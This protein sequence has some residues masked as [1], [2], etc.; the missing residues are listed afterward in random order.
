MK[1]KSKSKKINKA[2]LLD[3]LNDTYVKLSK[4]EGYRA[5]AANVWASGA[6]G[7]YLFNFFEPKSPR[8][9]ELGDPR[10]LARLDQDYFASFRGVGAAAGGNLP[11]PTYQS[12]ETLNPARPNVLQPGA[13][14]TARLRVGTDLTTAGPAKLTLR[15]QFDTSLTNSATSPLSPPLTV[16]L[17]GRN[18]PPAPIVKGWMEFTPAP[19]DIRTGFNEVAVTLDSAA[20]KPV[21]WLDLMLSVRHGSR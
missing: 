15:L 2:W 11:F 19:A 7:V 8:W 14:A 6:D 1:V 21:K 13:S 20:P 17:N 4:K 5:R 3:H 12:I 18:L 9:R 16:R 10:L